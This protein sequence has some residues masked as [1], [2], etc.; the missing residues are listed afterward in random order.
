MEVF[1][2]LVKAIASIFGCEKSEKNQLNESLDD[3]K[4]NGNKSGTN[5]NAFK[6]ILKFKYCY[7]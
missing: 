1:Q 2:R 7:Y 4:S 3:K 6:K 5:K